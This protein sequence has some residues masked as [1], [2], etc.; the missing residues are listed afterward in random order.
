MCIFIGYVEDYNISLF[1]VLWRRAKYVTRFLSGKFGIGRSIL[2]D[3]F[4]R[5]QK[6]VSSHKKSIFHC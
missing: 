5:I 1:N 4:V 6:A 3:S 2:L